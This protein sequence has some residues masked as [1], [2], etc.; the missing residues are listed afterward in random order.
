MHSKMVC[1]LHSACTLVF[2][3]RGFSFLKYFYLRCAYDL[4]NF[5]ELMTSITSQIK[6]GRSNL[7]TQQQICFIKYRRVEMIK[8][9]YDS[10]LFSFN[11][12]SLH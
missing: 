3:S 8:S 1:L 2:L 4:V 11:I 7:V 5:N 9:C 6:R 10:T 12:V